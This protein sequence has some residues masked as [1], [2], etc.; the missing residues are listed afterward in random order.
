MIGPFTYFEAIVLG[1][2]SFLTV[3]VF[4]ATLRMSLWL[5]WLN[6]HVTQIEMM[7]SSETERRAAKR[8]QRFP[9]GANSVPTTG[10]GPTG[11][12]VNDDPAAGAVQ[13]T[14]SEREG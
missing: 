13:S 4:G 5:E 9:G 11:H 1:H 6:W 3:V 14:A 7:L 10:D 2:L 12:C 8:H